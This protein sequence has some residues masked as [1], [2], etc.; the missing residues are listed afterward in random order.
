MAAPRRDGATDVLI[1]SV[2]ATTGWRAAARVFED[3]APALRA[4]PDDPAPGYATRAASS[5][6]PSAATPWPPL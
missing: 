3:L 4:A 6:R 1:V 2:G 5:W